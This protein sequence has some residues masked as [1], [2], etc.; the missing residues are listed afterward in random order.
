MNE[1]CTIGLKSANY[2]PNFILE[3]SFRNLFINH[4]LCH[5]PHGDAAVA[6]VREGSEADREPLVGESRTHHA[7]VVVAG[8]YVVPVSAKGQTFEA[9]Q[10]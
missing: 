3:R 7:R 1:I 10:K 5:V 9:I 2:H 8:D 4:H 6:P